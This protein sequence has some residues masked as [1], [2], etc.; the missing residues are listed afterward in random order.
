[1]GSKI[2][3]YGEGQNNYRGR[4]MP[5]EMRLNATSSWLVTLPH[6]TR[7]VRSPPTGTSGRHECMRSEDLPL[8]RR[9]KAWQ[10]GG[11]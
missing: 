7:R 9:V 2:D 6:H 10:L 4:A 8:M 1:M 5:W 3:G 11:V